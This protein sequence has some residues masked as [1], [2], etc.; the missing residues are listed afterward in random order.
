MIITKLVKFKD[1]TF[2]IRR[3]FLGLYWFKDLNTDGYWWSKNSRF[4]VDSC[5][6]KESTVRERLNLKKD[7]GEVVKE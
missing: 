1:G 6:G 2:G 5:R 4:F 3:G 7:N